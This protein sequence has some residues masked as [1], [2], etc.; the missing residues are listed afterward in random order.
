MHSVSTR[1]SSTPSMIARRPSKHILSIKRLDEEPSWCVD[2]GFFLSPLF[3]LQFCLFAS[4]TAIK[5]KYST[6]INN[7]FLHFSWTILPSN[8]CTRHQFRCYHSCLHCYRIQLCWLVMKWMK[9]RLM[10]LS[11]YN[12]GQFLSHL[13]TPTTA[14]DGNLICSNKSMWRIFISAGKLLVFYF[15]LTRNK[16][17]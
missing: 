6:P 11:L 3:Q 14:I 4:R 7:Y 8:K 17:N 13:I 2:C 12:E 16:K 1:S 15:S 9:N 5:W 10:H